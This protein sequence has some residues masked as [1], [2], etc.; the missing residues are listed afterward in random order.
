MLGCHLTPSADPDLRHR[1][2][3]FSGMYLCDVPGGAD[4]ETTSWGFMAHQGD[5]QGKTPW[6]CSAGALKQVAVA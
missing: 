6:A 3:M 4:S 1:S 2:R 5:P